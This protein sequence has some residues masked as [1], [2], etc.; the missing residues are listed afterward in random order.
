MNINLSKLTNKELKKFI[1]NTQN[2][3]SKDK[4][5]NIKIS[6]RGNKRSE[7]L[8]QASKAKKYRIE[9]ERLKKQKRNE[10]KKPKRTALDRLQT[11]TQEQFNKL[12]KST[13]K[14]EIK[15]LELEVKKR[16]KALEKADLNSQAVSKFLE[17][18]YGYSDTI[19]SLREYY[20]RLRSFLLDKRTSVTGEK[21]VRN[22]VKSALRE[23][24]IQINDKNY[25][26]FFEV[27][28]KAQELYKQTF[29]RSI[30]YEVMEEAVR[31]ISNTNLSTDEIAI[32]LSDFAQSAYER[33]QD[34]INELMENYRR[35][36]FKK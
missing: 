20:M 28:E 15:E 27:M 32:K 14:K 3:I 9:R 22:K 36:L 29:D 31:L 30:K 17:K 7:L 16:I 33:K 10:T 8:S 21:Q 34:A 1:R 18:G 2:L 35:K 23:Y 12:K 13:L 11:R 5:T 26:K 6:A 24:G 4:A 19:Q 25:D